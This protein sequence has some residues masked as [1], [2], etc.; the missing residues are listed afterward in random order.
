MA[1]KKKK[2]EKKKNGAHALPH[3][4]TEKQTSQVSRKSTTAQEVNGLDLNKNKST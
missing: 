1:L 2:K 3:V 4:H